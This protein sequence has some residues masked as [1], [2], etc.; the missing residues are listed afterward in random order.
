MS[1]FFRRIRVTNFIVFNDTIVFLD[2]LERPVGRIK[3][4][5]KVV[6]RI[7]RRNALPLFLSANE[8]LIRKA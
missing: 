3:C 7:S 4:S 5:R 6:K 8:N 1:N 2:F